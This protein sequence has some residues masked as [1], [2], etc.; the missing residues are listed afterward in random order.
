MRDR[1]LWTSPVSSCSYLEE[2]LLRAGDGATARVQ[3]VWQGADDNLVLSEILFIGVVSVRCTAFCD[4]SL[5]ELKSAYDELVERVGSERA[6]KETLRRS[7]GESVPVR[8][9]RLRFD[10]SPCY[11]VLCE[12][13]QVDGRSL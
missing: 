3:L 5:D 7:P 1:K 12:R 2:P 10:D 9:F 13:V 8:E 6:L 4:L 11:D